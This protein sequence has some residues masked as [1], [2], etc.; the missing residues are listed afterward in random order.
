MC[1]DPSA[2]GINDGNHLEEKEIREF[3][4]SEFEEEDTQVSEDFGISEMSH[5]GNISDLEQTDDSQND[6]KKKNLSSAN[7]NN[8]NNN[9]LR[10]WLNTRFPILG[11]P[12]SLTGV[13]F[14]CQLS[15]NWYC[16]QKPVIFYL[17][18]RIFPVICYPF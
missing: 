14:N 9:M 18:L 17:L 12:G 8:I 1:L 2:K 6:S 15:V 3:P 5:D 11:L 7:N 13:S 16:I 10:A 4:S